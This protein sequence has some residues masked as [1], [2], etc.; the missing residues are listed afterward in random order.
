[1]KAMIL[2]AG[3]GERMRPLTD[4]LPKPLLQVGAEPLIGWHLRRLAAVG[5]TEL[6]VNHAWLGDVL[7]QRIGDGAAWG[8][9]I[10][11]SREAAALETAGGIA[12]ALPLLGDAPFLVINGDIFT[13]VDLGALAR[14]ALT[15]DGRRRQ[16]HLI[17]VENPAHHPGGDF[18]LGADG[19]ARANGEGK[20][21]FSG[22]AAYHPAFFAGL[23]RPVEPCKLLP[24][25][26]AGMARG[27]VGAER[28]PGLWL[29]V[30]TPERLDEARALAAGTVA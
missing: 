24:L 8:V 14:H 6:V 7:E 10:A 25:L 12:Q 21:T 23:P 4:H 28:H 20:L 5:V 9:R 29:D 11:W 2:A 17:L 16:A 19:L 27:T 18:A 13:D 26:L 30:G 3:R 15:L 22:V 1:M